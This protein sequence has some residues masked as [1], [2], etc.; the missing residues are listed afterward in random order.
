MNIQEKLKSKFN[1]NEDTGIFTYLSQSGP[2]LKGSAAGGVNHG[3]V[4]ILFN[5]K[6][7]RAHRLECQPI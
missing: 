2:M 6:M 3:Y 4:Q 5:G 7:Q 1:Y